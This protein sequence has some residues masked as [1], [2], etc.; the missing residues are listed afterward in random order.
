MS[1]ADWIAERHRI[2]QAASEGPWEINGAGEYVSGVG[3]MVAPDDGG[4][5]GTDVEFIAD[6]RTAMPKMRAALEAV[7]ALH[8]WECLECEGIDLDASPRCGHCY[9]PWPCPTV[10]A[11][12]EALGVES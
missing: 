8:P 12:A 6:A 4:V 10:A 1:A 9:E 11:I 5:S 3:L 7:L 2:E